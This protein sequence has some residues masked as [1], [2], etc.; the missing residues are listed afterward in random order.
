MVEIFRALHTYLLSSLVHHRDLEGP[1]IHL[2]LVVLYHK[3]SSS[4]AHNAS[5]ATTRYFQSL[6]QPSNAPSTTSVQ[7]PANCNVFPNRDEEK[8]IQFNATSSSQYYPGVYFRNEF[9]GFPIIMGFP[10]VIML[11]MY[12]FGK[13]AVFPYLSSVPMTQAFDEFLDRPT[14]ILFRRHLPVPPYRGYAK[15]RPSFS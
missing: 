4:T 2:R 10:S 8:R 1:E 12:L 15:W 11:F 9:L 3:R 14:L 7:L 5:N 6:Q 13:N